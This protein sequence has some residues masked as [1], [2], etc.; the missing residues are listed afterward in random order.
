MEECSHMVTGGPEEIRNRPHMVTGVQEEIPFFSPGTSPE[1]PKKVRP[2]NQPQFRS[3]N[4]TATTEADQ[5]LLAHR[6][7]AMNS[8]SA[9]FHNN[10]NRISKLHKSV[11]TTRPTFESKSEK[12]DLFED[13]YRTSFK[14]HN[15]LTEE[16]KETLL[17][18]SHAM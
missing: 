1:K 15:Q 14:I 4:T 16:D 7:L 12:F 13:L 6:Q 3:E 18:L 5:I 2:T 17:P 11:S 9:Y 8:I 10:I